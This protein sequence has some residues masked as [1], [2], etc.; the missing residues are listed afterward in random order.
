[1]IFFQ[2]GI[3]NEILKTKCR[4]NTMLIRNE[5]KERLITMCVLFLDKFDFIYFI[6]T[7]VT[8]NNLF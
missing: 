5:T 6:L 7:L 8:R 3:F 1:M 2:K 4:K